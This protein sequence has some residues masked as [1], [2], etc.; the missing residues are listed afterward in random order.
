MTSVFVAM[1]MLV[2]LGLGAQQTAW[3]GLGFRVERLELAQCTLELRSVVK[4]NKNVGR[5]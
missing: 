2:V 4:K 5:R 1:I 3:S